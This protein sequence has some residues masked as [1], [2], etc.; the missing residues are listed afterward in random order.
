MKLYFFGGLFPNG[1]GT[2]RVGLVHPVGGQPY[3]YLDEK[4]AKRTFNLT[5]HHS[6]LYVWKADAPFAT[7]VEHSPE[8]EVAPR[9]AGVVGPDLL[10]INS[11]DADKLYRAFCEC[12]R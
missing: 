2:R 10:T 12:A 3:V 11:N 9:G 8:A 6:H 5:R 7:L 1:N 4:E